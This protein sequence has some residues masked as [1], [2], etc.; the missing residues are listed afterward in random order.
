MICFV[1][2]SSFQSPA[3][4]HHSAAALKVFISPGFWGLLSVSDL[5]FTP[6]TLYASWGTASVT[7]LTASLCL[8]HFH[9]KISYSFISKRQ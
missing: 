3:Q 8:G 1:V 9:T 2:V 6:P 5:L 4:G 7:G